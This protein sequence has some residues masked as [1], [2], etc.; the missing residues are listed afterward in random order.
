MGMQPE[1]LG[2]L[3]RSMVVDR[4]NSLFLSMASAWEIVMKHS[5]GKLE[6]PAD[7]ATY[8]R[9]RLAIS[10]ADILDISLE[11][12]F[13]LASIPDRHRD[14]FDRM[15]VAQALVEGMSLITADPHILSYPV[16]TIDARE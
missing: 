4:H 11:H 12:V 8:V 16:A 6:L 7:A 5:R 2:T 13:A 15:L 14:P 1:R 3:S 9:S 10:G